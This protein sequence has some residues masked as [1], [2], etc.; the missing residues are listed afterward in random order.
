MTNPLQMTF[1]YGWKNCLKQ[2]SCVSCFHASVRDTKGALFSK[3]VFCS[4][5][6]ALCWFILK[7]NNAKTPGILNVTDCP[8]FTMRINNHDNLFHSS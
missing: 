4:K 3:S 2:R 7:E 8:K 5:C 1:L 6:C